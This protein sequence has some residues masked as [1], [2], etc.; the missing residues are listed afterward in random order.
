VPLFSGKLLTTFPLKSCPRRVEET[1]RKK[2]QTLAD[3]EKG[4]CG[5][6]AKDGNIIQ[7]ER[8]GV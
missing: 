8:G 3:E 7:V 6:A 5:T 2:K 1:G 4:N